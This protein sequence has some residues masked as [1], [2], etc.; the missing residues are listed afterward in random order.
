MANSDS[1]QTRGNL[2]PATI[3][4]I[5]DVDGGKVTVKFMFNPHQYTVSLAHKYKDDAGKGGKKSKVVLE[6][7]GQKKLILPK[8]IFDTYVTEGTKSDVRAETKKLWTL[9]EP[10]KNKK[11]GNSQKFDGRPV[12]FS[13]GDFTKVAVSR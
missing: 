7:V 8:L 1:T 13:W 5:A 12:S 6:T 10:I 3:K 9:M 11:S 2:K 4:D